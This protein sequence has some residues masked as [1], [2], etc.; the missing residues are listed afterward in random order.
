M[1][2]AMTLSFSLANLPFR[3]TCGKFSV[4]HQFTF[5][6]GP[7]FV[8]KGMDSG[9]CSCFAEGMFFAMAPDSRAIRDHDLDC[10][11]TQP[12]GW[13]IGCMQTFAGRAFRSTFKRLVS[14]SE[15]RLLVCRTRTDI[16]D[17]QI[18]QEFCRS[19]GDVPLYS[20]RMRRWE[21]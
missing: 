2:K 12:S 17:A 21:A 19:V 5:R 8:A 18:G 1:S 4:G 13:A 9:S 15:G 6:T 20:A 14:A 7:S 3:R 16:C 10:E 11:M